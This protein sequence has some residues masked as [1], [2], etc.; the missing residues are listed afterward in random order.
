[1]FVLG[2]R[3]EGAGQLILSWSLLLLT[4]VCSF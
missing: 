1:M 2:S 4:K 3:R